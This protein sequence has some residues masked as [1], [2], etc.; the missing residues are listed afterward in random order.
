M[1]DYFVWVSRGKFP[2]HGPVRKWGQTDNISSAN[3]TDIWDMAKDGAP[4]DQAIFVAPT[5]AQK[6]LIASDSPDD[7]GNPPGVGARTICV[8]GLTA[9]DEPEAN[10]IITMNGT[11][12]VLTTK[13][14]VFIHRLE[15]LTKGGA[16]ACVGNISATAQADG[17]ITARIL[18]GKGQTQMAIR[19]I[20][21]VQDFEMTQFW[22]NLISQSSEQNGGQ[23]EGAEISLLV[24]PEPQT[25]LT[26]FIWKHGFGLSSVGTSY[27]RHLFRPTFPVPGPAI[28]KLQAL[29]DMPTK[30]KV[31]AGFDGVLIDNGV[32][33]Q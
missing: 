28:V 17:T 14:Y 9:W 21:S 31:S 11:T 27:I 7:N 8:Y 5:V 12:D 13:D 22:G 3:D 33:T 23:G 20:S 25:E 32:G 2:G 19:A 15:V 30:V 24:N 26:G 10:E 6:H 16:L 4:D 1:D 18:A 29:G